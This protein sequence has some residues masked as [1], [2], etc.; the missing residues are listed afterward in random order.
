MIDSSKL[1][2]IYLE[3]AEYLN[4]KKNI[5]KVG[6]TLSSLICLEVIKLRT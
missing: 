4:K 3:L 2:A 1:H 6:Y 5:T